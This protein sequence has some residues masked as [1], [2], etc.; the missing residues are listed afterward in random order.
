MLILYEFFS[1]IVVVCSYR[2]YAR[3]TPPLPAASVDRRDMASTNF[4]VIKAVPRVAT[5]IYQ[6]HQLWQE[7]K[8]VPDEILGLVEHLKA[9]EPIFSEIEDQ[10]AEDDVSTPFK[11]CLELSKKAHDSLGVL[12]AE[13]RTQLQAKKRAKR[14][15]AAVKIMLNKS[16]LARLEQSLSRCMN[17]LQLAIQAYQM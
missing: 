5:L 10:F 9:L 3:L 16:V 17:F 13:M 2:F 6:T 4:D 14:K 11:N 1:L 7:F 15:Y 12:V 8:D